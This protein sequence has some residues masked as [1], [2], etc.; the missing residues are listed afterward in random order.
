MV[1]GIG[2][3]KVILENKGQLGCSTCSFKSEIPGGTL[4]T[5]GRGGLIYLKE[6]CRKSSPAGSV[7]SYQLNQVRGKAQKRGFKTGEITGFLY[8][9]R[10]YKY[11]EHHRGVEGQG[12]EERME[13]SPR[14]QAA[15]RPW[16]NPYTGIVELASSPG[17][18]S[19]DSILKKDRLQLSSQETVEAREPESRTQDPRRWRI[20]SYTGIVKLASPPGHKSS[21]TNMY[22]YRTKYHTQDGN[23]MKGTNPMKNKDVPKSTG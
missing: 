19:S 13:P 23:K 16:I 10:R 12:E 11:R 4:N 9:I 21:D 15:R 22:M 3:E 18:K 6:I 8:V 7:I 1:R 14:T 20:K 2:K 17:H 5:G